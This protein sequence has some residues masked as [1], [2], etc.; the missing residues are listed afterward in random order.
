MTGTS[1]SKPLTISTKTGDSGQTGL[2][3]GQRLSKGSQTF[4]L[5]GTLDELNSW[6]GLVVAQFYQQPMFQHHAV[7]LKQQLLLLEEVQAWLYQVS[8]VVAAA[9]K[10]VMKTNLLAKLERQGDKLQSEMA[11]NWH[12]HFLYP[13]GSVM[14]GWLDVTRTVARKLEREFIRW[15]ETTTQ[16]VPAQILPTANRLSDYLYLLRCWANSVQAVTEK[17]FRAK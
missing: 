9:P 3:N 13:G 6:V 14:G 7:V 15:Q 2:A 16:T 12:Q 4:E 11:P 17:E 5:L 1:P 10:F 8:A